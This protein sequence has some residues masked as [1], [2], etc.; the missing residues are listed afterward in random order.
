M[1]LYDPQ[2]PGGRE[3]RRAAA[4][5]AENRSMGQNL[6]RIIAQSQGLELTLGVEP[7]PEHFLWLIQEPDP[8]ARPRE[9]PGVSEEAFKAALIG[10]SRAGKDRTGL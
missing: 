7:Q 3:D 9:N 1:T 5:M 2:R 4:L 8:E 10:I 6:A